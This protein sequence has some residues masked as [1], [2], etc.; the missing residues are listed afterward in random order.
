MYQNKKT[1]FFV[2]DE[3][4]KVGASNPWSFEPEISLIT[5][6]QAHK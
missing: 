4:Y 2:R 1:E 3:T 6:K 5:L